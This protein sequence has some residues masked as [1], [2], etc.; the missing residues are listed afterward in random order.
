[1]TRLHE[2]ASWLSNHGESS[3]N[4]VLTSY[5]SIVLEVSRYK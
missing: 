5:V 3:R 2:L 4:L 1:M